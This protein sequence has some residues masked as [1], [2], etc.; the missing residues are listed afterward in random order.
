MQVS[1]GAEVAVLA[2]VNPEASTGVSGTAAERR[3]A[4][5]MRQRRPSA[6]RKFASP[7]CVRPPAPGT[8]IWMPGAG[9]RTQE[10]LANLRAADGRRCLILSAGRLSAAVP[11]TPVLASGFTIAS[12]ATS[13]PG[14]TCIRTYNPAVRSA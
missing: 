1:P 12:T 3:P 6:A 10:G 9:G 13:A 8:H 11:E 5:K 7:S 14:E 4:L 2:I